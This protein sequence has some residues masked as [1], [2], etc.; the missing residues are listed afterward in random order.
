MVTKTEEKQ[1][2]QWPNEKELTMIYQGFSR[3][4]MIE[5]HEPL[6]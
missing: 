4:L 3:K 1:K 5:K 6:M 2:I